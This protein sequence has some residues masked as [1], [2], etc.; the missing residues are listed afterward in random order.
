MGPRAVRFKPTPPR[1]GRRW[2]RTAG[3]LSARLKKENAGDVHRLV[4][5]QLSRR[6]AWGFDLPRTCTPPSEPR[7]PRLP[8]TKI[9]ESRGPSQPPPLLIGPDSVSS[10]SLPTPPPPSIFCCCAPHTEG[11]L[12]GCAGSDDRRLGSA[13][14]TVAGG[15]DGFK[16]VSH[17]VFAGHQQLPTLPSLPSELGSSASPPPASSSPPYERPK[18]STWGDSITLNPPHREAPR[19]LCL[20]PAA[21]NCTRVEPWASGWGGALGNRWP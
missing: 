14:K 18:L 16:R 21:P 3:S 15:L 13:H 20:L 4:G 7:V 12:R 10:F 8:Q 6:P 2:R 17:S 19:P 5:K 11:F 1:L 9:Q